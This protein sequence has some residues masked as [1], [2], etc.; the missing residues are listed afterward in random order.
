MQQRR[1]GRHTTRNLILAGIVC[2]V[3]PWVTLVVCRDVILQSGSDVARV[4]GATLA[5]GGL[6][7]P[8]LSNVCFNWPFKATDL[9]A[10]IVNVV[11]YPLLFLLIAGIRSSIRKPSPSD[12]PACI[13]CGYNLTGNLSGRCPECGEPADPGPNAPPIGQ[14]DADDL[15]R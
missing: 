15:V 11:Y 10:L 1:S 7:G 9:G 13:E 12:A 4:F 14:N 5:Y 6:H 3:V 8:W 2:G